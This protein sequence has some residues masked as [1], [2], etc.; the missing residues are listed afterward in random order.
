MTGAPQNLHHEHVAAL[1]EALEAGEGQLPQSLVDECEHMLGAIE[2]RLALG[3]DYTIVA[4]AG[5]T[6]SGKSST[7]NALSGLE[8]ADAGVRRPTTARVNACSWSA[9]ATGLL[10]WLSVDSDRRITRNTILDDLE[11]PELDGLILLD[12]PD[13]DSVETQ[14][15]LIVDTILPLVDLLIW[16]VDPQ[17]Y[18]DQAL[19]AGYLRKLVDA[20]ASMVIAVN[21]MDRVPLAAQDLLIVDIEQ[22][23]IAD[24]L[25]QVVVRAISARTG[26]GIEDLRSEL[27]GAVARQSLASTRMRD[28]LAR[29][30]SLILKEVPG[31]VPTA[32]ELNL[33]TEVDKVMV[34]S[35]IG[36]VSDQVQSLQLTK[37]FVQ[38]PPTLQPCGPSQLAPLREQWVRRITQAMTPAWARLV[39]QQVPG[40]KEISLALSEQFLN[41][42]VPWHEVGPVKTNRATGLIAGVGAIVLVLLTI[43]DLA[44]LLP[45]SLW[46]VW[47]GGAAVAGG[48]C[49]YFLS[50]SKKIAKEWGHTQSRVLRDRARAAIEAALE[51]VYVAP[52]ALTLARHDKVRS[53]A[54]KVV[55]PRA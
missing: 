25:D 3:V 46:Q 17:K 12:L 39:D 24:G 23:L 36:A 50:R 9:D 35:G 14:H 16:V 2:E 53:L 38:V 33:T 48:F 30:A 51:K 29:L 10:D 34:A 13:H 55:H 49:G 44:G 45:W 19:H 54:H 18:A 40:A 47:L 1:R 20:Q 32:P 11:E 21:Q 37:N 26:M 42:E 31:D 4:L 5:G 28:E 27:K 43:T 8:F 7:F 6:G 15:K 41:V 22:M 52:V